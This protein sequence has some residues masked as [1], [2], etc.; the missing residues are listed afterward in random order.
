MPALGSS[1]ALCTFNGEAFIEAQ[2]ASLFAQQRPVDEIVA[3]D[4]ASNDSTVALLTSLASRS[5]VPMHVHRNPARLGAGANFERAMALTKGE[6]I[7]LCDQ[8]DVW[9][10]EK[11]ATCLIPFE[12]DSNVVLVHSDAQLVG[13]DMQSRSTTL[14][15][16]LEISPTERRLEDASRAFELLLKRNIVTGATAA[17]RRS[18]FVQAAPFPPEWVHDE[19]LAVIASLTGR[20]VR[21]DR[22]LI[23]YRQHGAN[24]IGAERRSAAQKLRALRSGRGDY[25]RRLLTRLTLLQTR[26][27]M[28]QPAPGPAETSLVER[29][30]AHA[31][32]R[33]R[34]PAAR[35]RRV[36]GIL[37]EM[38]TLRYFRY[39][40]GWTSVARDFLGPID[41]HDPC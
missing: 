37:Q 38:L 28:L 29:T 31:S 41:P 19:W 1:V 30:L 14:F 27:R 9:E 32:V 24:L 8:D 26:M 13:A 20:L 40:R 4:D 25:Q 39:A 17:V 16:A 3:V 15:A 18:V 33:A 35:W 7:F 21:V 11:I 22:P 23:R 34:M 6:I 36:P 5:P 10:P 12:S 2:V